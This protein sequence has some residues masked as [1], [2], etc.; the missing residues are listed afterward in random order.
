MALAK[1]AMRAILHPARGGGSGRS[2]GVSPLLLLRRRRFVST[3]T[4][5]LLLLVSLCCLC[6]SGGARAAQHKGASVTL[7]ARWQGTS[8]LMEAA[9]FLVRARAAAAQ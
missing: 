7:R 5:I 8:Y 4:P 1:G 2:A 6:W 3:V 9:E